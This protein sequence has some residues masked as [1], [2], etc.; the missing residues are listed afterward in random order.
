LK[1]GIDNA[2]FHDQRKFILIAFARIQII[3][4]DFEDAAFDIYV[5]TVE[6]L[7]L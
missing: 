1:G 4:I 3:A 5:K 2:A 6:I 7:P